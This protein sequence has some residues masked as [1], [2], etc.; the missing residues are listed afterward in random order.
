MLCRN[1]CV[2]LQDASAVRMKSGHKVYGWVRLLAA[3][4][5][6]IDLRVFPSVCVV[7]KVLSINLASAIRGRELNSF[8]CA[9]KCFWPQLGD[10]H[11]DG[12]Y[13]IPRRAIVKPRTDANLL[14]RGVT[15]F[16]AS[17]HLHLLVDRDRPH[18]ST[19]RVLKLHIVR[20]DAAF[21]HPCVVQFVKAEATI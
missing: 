11:M 4:P 12:N 7:H 10:M 2:E 14:L 21:E 8:G 15:Y 6:G 9:P 16:D 13:K 5:A 17:C 20:R 18:N 3:S 1:G 19:I